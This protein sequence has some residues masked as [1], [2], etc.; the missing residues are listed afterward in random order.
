MFPTLEKP[1]TLAITALAVGL[2]LAVTALAAVL[3]TRRAS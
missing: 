2:P 1:M 3:V